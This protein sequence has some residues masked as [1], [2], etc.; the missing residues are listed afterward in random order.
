MEF[1]RD[2]FGSGPLTYDQLADAVRERGY[3][4]VNA[5]G[6]AYVPKADTDNLR[7]QAET[8][9]SQ[10]GE[11][12]KKLD[13]YDPTWK[14]KAEQAQK[15]LEAQQFDFALEK[16]VAAAHPRN[17]KAVMA[18]LDREKL[19]FAGGDVIGLDKQLD[20]MKKG[21]DT[22]F[23][24]AAPELQKATG[25]SHQNAKAVGETDAPKEA[26]NQALRSLF[27]RSN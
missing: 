25:L 18:L 6:G 26:A 14:D 23:L 11:A 10:L 3:Q 19:S 8:L 20:A 27:G 9:A 4:V 21:E 15:R 2:L 13:G 24:F 1:L 7:R 16:A 17:V 12:N 5:A 22:A